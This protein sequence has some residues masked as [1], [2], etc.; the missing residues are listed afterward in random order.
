[1]KNKKMTKVLVGALLAGCVFGGWHY[2]QKDKLDPEYQ[3]ELDAIV[4]DRELS[5]SEIRKQRITEWYVNLQVPEKPPR[6]KWDA[7]H[8]QPQI[9]FTMKMPK[10]GD[11]YTM[12]MNGT[13]VRLLV[14]Q[15]E[16]GGWVEVHGP[17]RPMRS[18]DGRYVTLTYRSRMFSYDCALYDLKTQEVT[19]LGSGRCVSYHW[20]PDSRSVYFMNAELQRY[21]VVTK[22]LE[23]VRPK[24]NSELGDVSYSE[25][26][27]SY[28]ISLEQDR[29]V[30]ALSRKLKEKTPDEGTSILFRLS[31]MAYL[32]RKNYYDEACEAGQSYS[33][34]RRSFT[35]ANRRGPMNYYHIDAPAQVAGQSPQRW[36]IQ[37]GKW[38]LSEE[39]RLI[40][41]Y[42]QSDE[43]CPLSALNYYYQVA[44]NSPGQGEL[45]GGFS[46]YLPLHL[47][48]G[49]NQRDWRPFFPPLPTTVQYQESLQRQLKQLKE[50]G[51]G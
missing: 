42:R 37:E 7:V 30:Q 6:E 12:N 20:M 40:T 23:N 36:I 14:T 24:A 45:I 46:L 17:S 48:E 11:L 22:Q 9:M 29:L 15:K 25:H 28:F 13:D 38:F 16:L 34:D 18:P 33:L 3:K 51:R 26:A 19:A 10:Y 21:D 32:G 27:G 4:K 5:G 49:F 44:E 43:D 1:M 47:R 8:Q 41:R 50:Y 39:M 31:D 2:W 35:C